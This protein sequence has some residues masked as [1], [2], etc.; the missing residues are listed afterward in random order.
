MSLSIVTNIASLQTQRQ[1]TVH[2]A[3][4]NKSF[5]RLSSGLRINSAA[6]DAAGL[7]VADSLRADARIADVAIRNVGDGIS[8]LSVADGALNEVQNILTRMAEI[9]EISANGTQTQVTRSALSSEFVSLGSEVS[10]IARVTEF[11]DIKLLSSSSSVSFQV[12]LDSS[13]NSQITFAGVQATLE[14]LG[15]GDAGE[16]L[17]VAVTGDTTDLAQSAATNALDAITSAI[18]T[19]ALERGNVGA[20]ES[21]LTFALSNLQVLREN[22]TTAESQIRDADIALEA[23]L[24]IRNQILR[25]ASAAVLAQANQQPQVALQLLT[26]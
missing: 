5:E 18:D 8:L 20:T 24:L 9:A 3:A 12:G 2:T 17:S 1:L 15:L 19:L 23:A 13:A 10:R 25:D 6:D 16:A 26:A 14:S 21:R 4:L 22:L 11:N 7:A